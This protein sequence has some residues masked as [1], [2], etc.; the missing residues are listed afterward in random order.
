MGVNRHVNPKKPI[1]PLRPQDLQNRFQQTGCQFLQFIIHGRIV[2]AG[3]F[4]GGGEV[5][6]EL[7]LVHGHRSAS[8]L[9]P[10]VEDPC[11]EDPHT[12]PPSRRSHLPGPISQVPGAIAASDPP[13]FEGRARSLC[14][15]TSRH[16][17]V[18]NDRGSQ[19]LSNGDCAEWSGSLAQAP[20]AAKTGDLIGWRRVFRRS[21]G[22]KS[23]YSVL[24]RE[25]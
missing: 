19:N 12:I 15:C 8:N 14:A 16:R 21:P 22:A 11:V 18:K 20:C 6:R 5:S 3:Q 17:R 23:C 4:V 24:L 2:R 1:H 7:I 10:I 13:S 25:F 9:D